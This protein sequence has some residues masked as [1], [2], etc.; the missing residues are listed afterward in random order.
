MFTRT[1]ETVI[2]A[3]EG[4]VGFVTAT[5]DKQAAFLVAAVEGV[6]QWKGHGESWPM[7]CRAI[8]DHL[9][10]KRRAAVASLLDVLMDHLNEPVDCEP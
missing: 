6:A 1:N 10:E 2:T 7:Q 3:E 8:C 5:A 9:P 4:G